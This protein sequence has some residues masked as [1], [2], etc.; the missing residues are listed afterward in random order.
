[1]LPDVEEIKDSRRVLLLLHNGRGVKPAS[2]SSG[3]YPVV[4]SRLSAGQFTPKT[5]MFAPAAESIVLLTTGFA[6]AN[7]TTKEEKLVMKI[8]KTLAVIVTAA[9]LNSLNLPAQVSTQE[10]YNV[11]FRA[12]CRPSDNSNRHASRMNNRDLIEQC[13][14]DGFTARELRRNYALVYNPAT[15][16][17]QVVN[18]ADGSFVCDALI[19]QGGNSVATDNRLTRLTFVFSPNQTD[20]IGTAVITERPVRNSNRPRAR[21]RGRIQF[22]TLSGLVG[23]AAAI[24]SPTNSASNNG[25]TN[26]VPDLNSDEDSDS[27]TSGN[28][29]QAAAAANTSAA[30]EVCTGSFNVG[31][32]FVPG[33]ERRARN[34]NTGKGAS[35][36][37]ENS[38]T[39]SVSSRD[40]RFVEQAAQ[41]GMLEVQ[42][43][44]LAQQNSTNTDVIAYGQRLV[45]DHSAANSELAQIANEKG[46]Q[47]P[48]ALDNAHQ[49][50][51]DRLAEMQGAQFDRAFATEAVSSHKESIDLFQS[52]VSR[53]SDDDLQTFA[54]DQLPVLQD[55]LQEAQ[56]LRARV[57]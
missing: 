8:S 7:L 48:T 57:Q 15:D 16:S 1:M 49:A 54:E 19:F 12:V 55:H 42:L 20:S 30:V 2:V 43:G 11:N 53:G 44:A 51:Y 21:I 50:T 47:I 37:D 18:R 33:N 9:A 6:R 22:T 52:E 17:L 14:G 31:R 41:A 24:E 10:L 25:D 39:N 27:G 38:D 36:D 26:S 5:P 4:C 29:V 35:I 45:Q 28:F 3:K 46:V 13:V 32:Q 34:G 23:T 40:T 56:Q